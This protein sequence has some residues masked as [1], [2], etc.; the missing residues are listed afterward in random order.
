[1][2]SQLTVEELSA[3]V[4]RLSQ[5]VNDLED[6]VATLPVAPEHT[7]QPA[8]SPPGLLFATATEWVEQ[9]L[10]SIYTRPTPGQY[11]WCPL[12][13]AHPE[14]VIR[15]EALWRSWEVARL[16]GPASMSLW[17]R[18]HL[19]HHLPILMGQAGPFAACNLT[20]HIDNTPL[21]TTP[22]PEGWWNGEEPLATTPTP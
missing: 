12:W 19:D 10:V 22:P 17:H 14:A 1:M 5:Q 11:R 2:I 21:P 3:E 8:T 4:R 18:D 7:S 13:W 20:R 6:M 15:L 9:F 16:G